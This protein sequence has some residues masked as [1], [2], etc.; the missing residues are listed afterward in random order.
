[1]YQSGT[2]PDKVRFYSDLVHIYHWPFEPMLHL[3]EQI[4]SSRYADGI[5]PATSHAML[6]VGQTQMWEWKHEMLEIEY[7]PK[8]KQFTFTFWERPTTKPW[9]THC[10]SEDGFQRFERCMAAKKWFAQ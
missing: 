2:W 6:M 7:S 1:M 8:D 5:Y 9:V 4:A 10:S 3:V